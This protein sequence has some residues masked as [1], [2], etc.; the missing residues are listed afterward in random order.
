MAN[1]SG[2]NE[3]PART[4]RRGVATLYQGSIGLASF[5]LSL[6]PTTFALFSIALKCH[7]FASSLNPV[8]WNR[9]IKLHYWRPY[10]LRTSHLFRILRKALFSTTSPQSPPANAALHNI[11]YL[12]EFKVASSKLSAILGQIGNLLFKLMQSGSSISSVNRRP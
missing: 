3:R 5:T 7:V 4:S 8:I 10:P 6:P 2:L 11:N 12:E 9:V 1:S